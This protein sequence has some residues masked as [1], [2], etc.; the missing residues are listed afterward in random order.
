MSSKKCMHFSSPISFPIV[1][2]MQCNA[3]NRNKAVIYLVLE[4]VSLVKGMNTHIR[5]VTLLLYVS[6]CTEDDSS[7]RHRRKSIINFTVGGILASKT[8]MSEIKDKTD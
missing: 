5:G 3:M 8:H 4:N 2:T 7:V 1:E 6:C